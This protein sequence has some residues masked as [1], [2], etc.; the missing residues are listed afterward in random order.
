MA[1]GPASYGGYG[2]TGDGVTVGVGDDASG[3]YHIDLDGRIT[4]FNP[5]AASVHGQLVNGIVGA[6]ATVDPF[7]TTMTPHVLLVD[8]YFDNILPA[9]GAMYHDYNMTITNNS[10]EIIAADCSYSGTY[11]AYSEFVDTLAMQYPDVQHVFASGNDGVINCAPY[12]PGFATVG[13]GYQPA[14]NNIVV[15][16]MTDYLIEASDESRGPAKDGRLKPEIIAI[17][18]GTYSTSPYNK[19]VW[20]AGTSMASPQVA[21]GLAALTQQYKLLHGGTQPRADLLKAILLNGAM[22]LGNPGPDYSYGYGA[23]DMYRSLQIMG[24]NNYLSDSVATGD[25][26][27]FTIT[28]PPNTGQLKVMLYWNDVPGSPYAATELVNDLDLTV[29]DPAASAHLPLILD[30]TPANV[31]NNATPGADH[32][33]NSE[34]VTITHPVAGGYKIAVKGYRVPAGPQHYVV[35]Y[36]MIPDSMH[37][38]FPVGGEQLPNMTGDSIRIFWDAVPDGNTFTGQFS[39]R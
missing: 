36:D 2:L 29:T 13:G 10:Y 8:H 18:L 38:T 23:M 24:N 39:P 6:A 1:A 31:N 34:Q 35:A 14:K 21:G 26:Q 16:S 25:S 15:G 4:N 11:D 9:T 12:V 32:T 22:D 5:A 27:F 3:A 20:D 17:G 30:P 33:N 19:Y 28:V 37:L 7:A